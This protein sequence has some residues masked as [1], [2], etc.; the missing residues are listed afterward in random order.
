MDSN[1]KIYM[2]KNK[3]KNQRDANEN[4]KAKSLRMI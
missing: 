1:F 2:Q 3:N 4:Y